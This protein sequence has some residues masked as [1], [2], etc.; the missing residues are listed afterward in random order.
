L[1]EEVLLEMAS[2][3]F[4]RNPDTRALVKGDTAADWGRVALAATLMQRAGGGGRL[5]FLMDPPADAAP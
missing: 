3:V 5:G 2:A 4:R 1:E